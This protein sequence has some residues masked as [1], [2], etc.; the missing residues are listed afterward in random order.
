MRQ[1]ADSIKTGADLDLTN[2]NSRHIRRL[3]LGLAFFRAAWRAQFGPF[4]PICGEEMVFSTSGENCSP[5]RASTDHIVPRAK[6]G[7]NCLA[8]YQVICQLCNE[9]K[10][11]SLIE[12]FEYVDDRVLPAH[13]LKT[14][15]AERRIIQKYADAMPP[16]TLADKYP[17]LQ[18]PLDEER[19]EWFTPWL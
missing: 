15:T 2:Y 16:A 17:E 6:G 13:Y 9:H 18:A 12:G 8:N 5:R 7:T 19:A 3:H 1:K 10:A 11:D 14:A 4:C